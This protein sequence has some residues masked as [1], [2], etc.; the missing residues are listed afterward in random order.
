MTYRFLL[1]Y[2]SLLLPLSLSAQ[3]EWKA[4]D[5]PDS[6]KN[7]GQSAVVRLYNV[8]YKANTPESGVCT[9]HKVVTIL[10]KRGDNYATWSKTTEE[11]SSAIT[12]FRGFVYDTDGKV[13]KKL[14]KGDIHFSA[15]SEHLADEVNVNYYEPPT[16][17]SYPYTVEYEWEVKYTKNVLSYPWFYPIDGTNESMQECHYTLILNSGTEIDYRCFNTN[18]VF[19]KTSAAETDTYTWI[20]PSQRA[21]LDDDYTPS[22]FFVYPSVLVHP[23]HFC[24]GGVTGSQESWEKLGDWSYSLTKGRDVLPQEEQEKVKAMTDG[25]PTP[26]EKV[27]ALYKYLGEKTRYVSIQLG[28]GGYQPMP[29]VEVART[30]FGDCKALSN[31][32]RAMLKVIGIPSYLT[33]IS[34]VYEDLLPDFPNFNQ[35][36]HVILCVPMETD[37]LWLDCTAAAVIPFPNTP[38]NL[39][40]HQCTVLMDDG[41]KLQRIPAPKPEDNAFI[42]KADLY[43]SKDGTVGDNSTFSAICKGR[44]FEKY[45][46]LCDKGDKDKLDAVNSL[47]G[48]HNSKLTGLKVEKHTEGTPEVTMQC[49]LKAAYARKSGTR[50]FVPT[51]PFTSIAAPRFTAHRRIP[52]AISRTAVYTDTVTIHLPEGTTIESMPTWMLSNGD[53]NTVVMSKYGLIVSSFTRPDDKTLQIVF[54]T[55]LFKGQYPASEKDDFTAFFKSLSS[56]LNESFVLVVKP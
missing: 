11:G 43:L 27:G 30:G 7:D 13:F 10:D 37:T 4:T 34:T 31:Y 2:I 46:G 33:D 40:G 19:T 6:L 5:I 17:P 35:M 22:H 9:F 38:F 29:A 54:K 49:G 20:V 55:T 12:S 51:D 1:I 3:G 18:A 25:L 8:V 26:M 45:M 48:L 36:D 32:M 15:Y 24:Y 53:K 50:L 28:I 14:K 56:R 21:I 52:I 16:M 42:T 23:L 44:L 47:I 39:R 41:A